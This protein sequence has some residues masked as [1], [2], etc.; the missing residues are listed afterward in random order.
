[1]LWLQ[2][3]KL[4]FHTADKNIAALDGSVLVSYWFG[5]LKKVSCS[6]LHEPCSAA[7]VGGEKRTM[8][9]GW[10]QCTSQPGRSHVFTSSTNG[11]NT[12]VTGSAAHTSNETAGAGR[13]KSQD[14][15]NDNDG[16]PEHK[17]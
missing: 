9:P 3:Q 5:N 12:A 15:S 8:L 16:H 14:I 11:A 4:I 7:A 2:Q 10:P 1:M 6:V 13:K 17:Q